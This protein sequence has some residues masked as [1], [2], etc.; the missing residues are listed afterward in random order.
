M[1]YQ[2][3]CTTLSIFTYSSYSSCT[4]LL[5]SLFCFYFFYLCVIHV[6]IYIFI[7]V[8]ISTDSLFNALSNNVYNTLYIYILIILI[9]HPPPF[10]V[11]LLLFLL[12]LCYTCVYIY[13][14]RCI[15]I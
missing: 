8:Y 15:Y 4:L 3:M 12:S 2:I 11:V 6:C 5:F 14:Y 9:M 7:G 1:L 10:F 13:F